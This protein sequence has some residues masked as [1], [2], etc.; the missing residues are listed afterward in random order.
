MAKKGN[1]NSTF[2][3]ICSNFYLCLKSNNKMIRDQTTTDQYSQKSSRQ[4]P[5][6]IFCSFQIL[7][8]VCGVDSVSK[9]IF[10]VMTSDFPRCEHQW[11]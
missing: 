3:I 9:C 6:H 10:L 1:F 2:Y 4:C 5:L 11:K 8:D 7:R